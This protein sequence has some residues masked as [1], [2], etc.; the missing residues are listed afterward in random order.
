MIENLQEPR[1]KRGLPVGSVGGTA[2]RG[3]VRDIRWSLAVAAP[4]NRREQV[5]AAQLKNCMRQA[6]EKMERSQHAQL[7]VGSWSGPVCSA[8]AALHSMHQL[9]PKDNAGTHLLM[10]ALLPKPPTACAKTVP[11]LRVWQDYFQKTDTRAPKEGGTFNMFY[12]G[13]PWIQQSTSRP[14]A[15][16]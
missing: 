2:F 12:K 3:Q 15:T 16:T 1:A 5:A 13:C 11:L 7:D 8:I 14:L 9:L 6:R 4:Y 10:T